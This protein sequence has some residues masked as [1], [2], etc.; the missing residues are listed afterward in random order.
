MKA[1]RLE[2]RPTQCALV[3]RALAERQWVPFEAIVQGRDGDGNPFKITQQ[4]ARKNELQRR[5][6]PIITRMRRRDPELD[7]GVEYMASDWRLKDADAAAVSYIAQRLAI[8]AK[9]DGHLSHVVAMHLPHPSI[10]DQEH[11]LRVVVGHV[12]SEQARGAIEQYG[13]HRMAAAELWRRYIDP[14]Y[15]DGVTTV[16]GCQ[17]GTARSAEDCELCRIAAFPFCTDYLCGV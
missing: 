12:T 6:F 7:G 11:T 1:T 15:G 9:T 5:G 8:I 3:L 14:Y 16:R 13:G 2:A 10:S 17:N 4:N